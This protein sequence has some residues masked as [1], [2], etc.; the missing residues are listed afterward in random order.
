V[1]HESLKSV[2]DK[3]AGDH[4]ISA[5]KPPEKILLKRMVERLAKQHMRRGARRDTQD[6]VVVEAHR[7]LQVRIQSG[8]IEHVLPDP[9]SDFGLIEPEIGALPPTHIGHQVF[10]Q[11]FRIRGDRLLHNIRAGG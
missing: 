8:W 7:T 5:D 10:R 1:K 4:L 2:L 9:L 3:L 6:A 11:Y